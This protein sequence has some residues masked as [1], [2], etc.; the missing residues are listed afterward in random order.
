MPPTALLD[1]LQAAADRGDA[2]AA[3]FVPLFVGWLAG[4]GSK[5]VYGWPTVALCPNRSEASISNGATRT[6]DTLQHAD[7]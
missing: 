4:Q 7:P 2:K 6:G 5:G 1:A 3:A